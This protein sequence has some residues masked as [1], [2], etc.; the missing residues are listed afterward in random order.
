[1]AEKTVFEKIIDREIPADIV[2]E[3]ERCIAFF[4]IEPVSK[5]HT[6][7]I[8]KKP[9]QW[10]YEVPDDELSYV[11]NMSKR[12][13]KAMVT[14]IPCDLVQ[15]NVIG[16]A[17]PHFHIHLIPRMSNDSFANLKHEISYIDDEEKFS[18]LGKIR[19]VL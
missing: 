18:Y 3:D 7:V 16:D 14:G 2:Y 1:M 12:I 13:M 10:M 19:S 5:G 4:T 8:P 9:Y 11:I 6:L 15:V 17:V